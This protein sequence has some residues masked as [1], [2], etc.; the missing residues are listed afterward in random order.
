MI[1]LRNSASSMGL[2]GNTSNRDIKFLKE[3]VAGLEKT[4]EGNR[5]ILE[6]FKRLQQRARDVYNKYQDYLAKNNYDV[7][8][9]RYRSRNGQLWDT[10]WHRV[11]QTSRSGWQQDSSLCANS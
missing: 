4:E 5:I 9:W 2:T 3:S 11:S 8:G 6:A 1:I 10:P 7:T